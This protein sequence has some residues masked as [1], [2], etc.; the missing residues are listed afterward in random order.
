MASPSRFG[1]AETT[2]WTQ[3]A[4]THGGDAALARIIHQA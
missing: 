4:K 1:D 3:I 2:V